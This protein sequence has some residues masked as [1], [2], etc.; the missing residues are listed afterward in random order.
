VRVTWQDKVLEDFSAG[1]SGVD[2]THMGIFKCFLPMIPPQPDT[3]NNQLKNLCIRIAIIISSEKY[4][5]RQTT[6]KLT[7]TSSG[8]CLAVLLPGNGV[9]LIMY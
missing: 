2:E 9:R 5:D 1:C 3:N 7:N 4:T 6:V 8:F